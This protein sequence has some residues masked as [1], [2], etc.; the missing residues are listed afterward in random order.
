MHTILTTLR[1]QTAAIHHRLD[2][3][4]I[5]GKLMSNEVAPADFWNYLQAF[6]ALHAF[7][8]P[9]IYPLAAQ[10]IRGIEQNM[11][12]EALKRDL[13]RYPQFERVEMSLEGCDFPELTPQNA[14]G[15]LYVLEGS[16]LGGRMISKHLKK[17]FGKEWNSDFLDETPIVSWKSILHHLEQLPENLWEDTS[18]AA[19][20]MFNFVEQALNSAAH[21][22]NEKDTV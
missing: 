17:H 6:Y 18:V 11:R 19:V 7:V 13:L 4:P 1:E 8:E 15:A 20:G 16:R 2:Q 10:Q 21:T 9:L 3:S 14:L 22:N 12:I 5:T